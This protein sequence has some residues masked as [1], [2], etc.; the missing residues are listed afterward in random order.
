M[1]EMIS[2][3]DDAHLN[4]SDQLACVLE[5]DTILDSMLFLNWG[6]QTIRMK[7]KED[8]DFLLKVPLMRPFS[9][10]CQF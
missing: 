1:Q 10:P 8:A 3:K 4:S 6:Y 2:E 5:S 7:N 9:I